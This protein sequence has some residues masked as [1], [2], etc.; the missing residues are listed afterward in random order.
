LEKEDEVTWLG[1]ASLNSLGLVVLGLGVVGKRLP[2]NFLVDKSNKT[3]AIK[4]VR[5]GATSA[6]RVTDLLAGK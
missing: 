3:R 5:A 4:C 2:G 1:I 6:I